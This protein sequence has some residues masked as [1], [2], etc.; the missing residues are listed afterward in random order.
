MGMALASREAS[1]L[2][3]GVCEGGWTS[4]AAC[5]EPQ[6]R[7]HLQTNRL[8]AGAKRRNQCGITVRRV[9]LLVKQAKEK[10][11]VQNSKS[12]DLRSRQIG[13]STEEL[14]ETTAGNGKLIHP[15]LKNFK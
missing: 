11:F 1:V 13:P 6:L 9:F 3:P 15:L 8:S 2:Q 7:R 12:S 5:R 10:L 4:G 14:R